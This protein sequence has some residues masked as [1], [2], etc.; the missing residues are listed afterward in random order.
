MPQTPRTS[1]PT[2]ILHTPIIVVVR[3]VR[4]V[5]L[6]RLTSGGVVAGDGLLRR[7]RDVGAKAVCEGGEGGSEAAAALGAVC[8][9]VSGCGPGDVDD[10][11][12]G[13]FESGRGRGR[14]KADFLTGDRTV[15]DNDRGRGGG[16]SGGRHCLFVYGL[17]VCCWWWW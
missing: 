7:G 3:L 4:E 14:R 12:G 17:V 11:D 8:G 2:T 5:V 10:L 13:D 15:A 1:K 9:R 16:G 6:K